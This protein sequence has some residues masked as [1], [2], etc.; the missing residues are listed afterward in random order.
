MNASAADP[1]RRALVVV[2]MQPDFMPG[3]AL[4]VDGGD[5]LVE[6]V[7]R[8]LATGGFAL[9]VA[10]QDWHPA[11]HVSFASQHAGRAPFETLELYGREQTLWPDHGVQGTRG[12]A[13]QPALDQRPFAAVFRKGTSHDVDS[14]SAFRNNWDRHGERPKTGLA[15]YLRERDVHHVV[16]VGLARDYCVLWSAEDAADAGF[17]TTVL[18]ELT[19]PVDPASDGR[20]RAALAARGVNID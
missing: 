14:Y 15:G 5:A 2:D 19:R 16:L 1:E 6:P 4:P 9:A 7:N 20:V 3:G 18:W 13:L 12:A 11:D 8:L 10:T 17:E